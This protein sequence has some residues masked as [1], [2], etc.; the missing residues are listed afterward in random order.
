MAKHAA[1]RTD[2]SHARKVDG[3]VAPA[4]TPDK[5]TIREDRKAVH[6]QHRPDREPTAEEEVAAERG[7]A[8]DP[9][10]AEA[11]EEAL[12]RGARQEGEGRP[13]V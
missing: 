1:K 11:Y 9:K 8:V 3:R 12:E 7:G 4:T 13:G 2:Q 5:D 6:N 10:V